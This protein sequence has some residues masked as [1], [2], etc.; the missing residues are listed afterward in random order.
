M[1]AVAF[2]PLSMSVRLE[3]MASTGPRRVREEFTAPPRMSSPPR[4]AT[5]ADRPTGSR[6]SPASWTA[7][8]AET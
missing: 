5:V 1:F 7:E 3:P 2:A 6:V 8:T 4:L